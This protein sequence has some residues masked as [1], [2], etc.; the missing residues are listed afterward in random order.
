M[1]RLAKSL[2]KRIDGGYLRRRHPLRRWRRAIAWSVGIIAIAW[3]VAAGFWIDRSGGGM[4]PRLVGSLHNP[5][6]VSRAHAYFENDCAQCHTGD[7]KGGFFRGVSDNA[8][9]VCHDAAIHSERQKVAAKPDDVSPAKLVLAMSDATHPHHARSAACATCHVE[10]RGAEA[11]AAASDQHCVQCHQDIALATDPKSATGATTR[12]ARD[13]NVTAFAVGRHPSFDVASRSSPGKLTFP[14]SFHHK[15]TTKGAHTDKLL[16]DFPVGVENDCVACHQAPEPPQRFDGYPPTPIPGD[17]PA[18]FSR[19]SDRRYMQPVMFS[20]HCAVCH[21][22]SMPTFQKKVTFTPASPR[23]ASTAPTSKP[24]E[25]EPKEVEIEWDAPQ[26]ELPHGETSLVRGAI[27]DQLGSMLKN[28]LRGKDDDGGEFDVPAKDWLLAN[29]KEA[30]ENVDQLKELDPEKLAP[31]DITFDL[32]VDAY[33][34]RVLYAKSGC[35]KCHEIQGALDLGRRGE[36][37]SIGVAPTGI[38]SSSRRW[39]PH[40]S[41]DHDAHRSLR[42]AQCHKNALTSDGPANQLLPDMTAG[43]NSTVAC[44]DCHKPPERTSYH[45]DTRTAPANCVTCH[46]YHDRSKERPPTGPLMVP[47]TQPTTAPSPVASAQNASS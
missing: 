35:A 20:R 12:S 32:V 31:E 14:H 25:V 17:R 3:F 23:D 43:E 29:L 33:T 9:L 45:S 1:T 2:G 42:C 47:A 28:G 30:M 26:T 16:K 38:G 7:G 6:P 39:F 27:A 8:C 4:R 36:R 10:H 40:S 5:G 13:T 34:A 44:V 11:L 41:F 24:V 21:A 18:E 22:L 46:T 15:T 37:I 19:S